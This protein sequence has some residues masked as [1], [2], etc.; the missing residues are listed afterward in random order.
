MTQTSINVQ[1][2]FQQ[3]CPKRSEDIHFKGDLKLKVLKEQLSEIPPVDVADILE[4]LGHEQRMAIFHELD[5]EH[6]SDTLE[7]IDPRVQREMIASMDKEKA[8]RLI[9]EMTPGQAA[10]LL[11]VLPWWEVQAIVELLDKEKAIK[12]RALLEKQEEKILDF[13]TSSFLRFSPEK[14]VMEVRE[15]F[16]E[17]ARGKA[18]IMY[19]YVLDE[20][21]KLIG[22]LDIRELLVAEGENKLKDIMITNV[23]SLNPQSTLRK[24]SEL[25]ARYQFRALPVTDDSGRMLGVIPYRDVVELRHRYV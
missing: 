11:A 3:K 18:A 22:V 10:D 6:A 4:E 16:P 15:E 7:E 5:V 25:F 23:V 17:A 8:A 13:A 1:T 9:N 14:T 21:E 2:R 19:V 24:A 20:T 12:V